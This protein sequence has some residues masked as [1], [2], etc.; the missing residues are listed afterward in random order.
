R[1][2]P[3]GTTT[4]SQSPNPPSEMQQRRDESKWRLRLEHQ[5]SLPHYQFNVQSTEELDRL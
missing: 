5:A 1:S 2:Q 4:L 3:S